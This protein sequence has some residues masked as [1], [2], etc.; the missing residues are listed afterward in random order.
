MG[1]ASRQKLKKIGNGITTALVVLAVIF[2]AMLAGARLIGLQVYSVI[3]GSMEPSY[4]VGS[5]IYVQEVE[6]EEVQVG[7]VI[8]FVLS[9][10]TPAT[11][12]VIRIDDEN[13]QFFTKGDANDSEDMAPVHFKNLLGKPIC[14]VP[15]L[16]YIAYYI[17][18][19]PGLYIA[20][21]AGA[22]LLLLVFLPDLLNDIKKKSKNLPENRE[23]GK[24][25]EGKRQKAPK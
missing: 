4:P 5:L 22:G 10:E 19:P 8:T 7:D 15:Y 18:H 23:K 24:S 11:H 2:A 13:Q 1:L 6:P 17:K 12:R 3:S 25:T 9:N 21:A 14:T 16:G 20:I